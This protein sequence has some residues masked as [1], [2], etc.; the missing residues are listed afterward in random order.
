MIEN[1][2]TT[3]EEDVPNRKAKISIKDNGCGIPKE[4]Q[5]KIFDP[6]F[7]TKEQGSGLGLAITYRIIE[8]HKGEITIYSEE[9]QGTEVIMYFPMI[10]NNS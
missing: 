4:I 10:S 2:K 3:S 9:G 5:K 1:R 8:S 7:T 6:F